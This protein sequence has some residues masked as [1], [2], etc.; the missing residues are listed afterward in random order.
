[1]KDTGGDIVLKGVGKRYRVAGGTLE[2]LRGIDLAIPARAIT[3]LVGR[4]GC[5]KTT[6][7]RLTSGLDRAYTGEILRPEN[8]RTAVVFQEPRLMPWLNVEK[9]IAFGL[10]RREISPEKIR[11][12]LELTGLTGFA[13][14]KPS[15]LSGGMAQRAAIARAL[16]IE[17]QFL[18]M[19][20]PFAAL[21]DFTRAS[22]RQALLE[23]HQKRACGIL[24]ITHS[25]EEA[26]TLGDQIVILRDRQIQ[27]VY[28]LTEKPLRNGRLGPEAAD[29]KEEIQNQI[30]GSAFQGK[31]GSGFPEEKENAT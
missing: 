18:L 6:L 25:I 9:N 12:L 29:L 19:D 30:Q 22:M 23:I 10:K 26:L 1:M 4:S 31:T 28:H 5:G 27:N 15:Q 3:V 14:A 17:P 24:F 21:D 16:A 20:E 2:V 11:A 13:H 8:S 7:L